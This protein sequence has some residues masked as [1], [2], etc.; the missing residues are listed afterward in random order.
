MQ[1]MF[2]VMI[3]TPQQIKANAPEGATHYEICGK[4]KPYPLYWKF[5]DDGMFMWQELKNEWTRFRFMNRSYM[6]KTKPL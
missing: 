3:M 1:R 4:E 2:G 5:N 6:E